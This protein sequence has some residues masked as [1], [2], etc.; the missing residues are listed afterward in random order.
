MSVNKQ[1]FW[2]RTHTIA[3]QMTKLQSHLSGTVQELIHS[4]T[5]KCHQQSRVK[6]VAVLL[7]GNALQ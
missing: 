7:H 6:S 1:L 4:F 5:C 3:T 2:T